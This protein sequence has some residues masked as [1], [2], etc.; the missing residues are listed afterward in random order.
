VKANAV[1]G[2]IHPELGIAMDMSIQLKAAN[3]AICTL[4]LSFNN[5]GPLGTFFRYICDNGTYIARYDDLV[6]GK[7]EPIDVSKVDVSINGIELQDREFVAAIREG[8]E[9]NSSVAQVLPCYKVLHDL[10]QQ[11]QS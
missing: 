5:D 11:L 2:P 8:R 1:E 4:S 10:E 7:E 6:N 9:P 3:G